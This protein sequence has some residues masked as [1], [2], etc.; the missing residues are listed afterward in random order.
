MEVGPVEFEPDRVQ[1]QLQPISAVVPASYRSQQLHR[2]PP[3]A[4]EFERAD[5]D[6]A[7][8]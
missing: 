1:P 7:D 4:E 6:R 5:A 2:T 3:S 8:S